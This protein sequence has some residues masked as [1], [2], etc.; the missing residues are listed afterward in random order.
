MNE[1]IQYMYEPILG[2]NFSRNVSIHLQMNQFLEIID[3][4]DSVQWMGWFTAWSDSIIESIQWKKHS[5]NGSI[6]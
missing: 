2:M 6:Q 5:M 4:V 3:S 1:S